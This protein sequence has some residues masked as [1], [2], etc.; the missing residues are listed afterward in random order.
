V[1]IR[2]NDHYCGN[3]LG[4]LGMEDCIRVSVSHYNTL[5]EVAR[6]LDAMREV[7]L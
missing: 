2:K 5:G 6:F 1:H 4:P 3:V 7:T